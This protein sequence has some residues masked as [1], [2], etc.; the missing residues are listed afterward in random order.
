MW[1]HQGWVGNR[2]RQKPPGPWDSA[3][4]CGNFPGG[5]WWLLQAAELVGWPRH[6]KLPGVLP[7]PG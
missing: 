7:A 4:A 1:L 6:A 5:L 3:E 2:N